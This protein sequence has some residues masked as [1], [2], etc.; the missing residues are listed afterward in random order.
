MNIPYQLL[1]VGRN[2][3]TFLLPSGKYVLKIPRNDSGV[4]DNHH[5]ARLSGTWN[6]ARCKLVNLCGIWCLVMEYLNCETIYKEY[7]SLPDWTIGVDCCQVGYNRK[8]KLL[9]YDFGC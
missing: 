3:V 6:Y 9:A 4:W 2:R 1:G 8:G 7:D 5:E